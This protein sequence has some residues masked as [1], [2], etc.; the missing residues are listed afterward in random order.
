ML[1]MGKPNVNSALISLISCLGID[2]SV[3]R[4]PFLTTKS[5]K[6]VANGKISFPISPFHI[7]D[8]ELNLFADFKNMKRF[9]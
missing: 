4:H 6:I 1:L 5:T 2:T 9:S 7:R 8:L 3:G